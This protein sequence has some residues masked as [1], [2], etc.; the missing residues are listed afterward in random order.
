MTMARRAAREG[1]WVGVSSRNGGIRLPMTPHG[2]SRDTA[3]PGTGRSWVFRRTMIASRVL[4]ALLT[5]GGCS[6][7]GSGEAGRRA[8][9]TTTTTAPHNPAPGIANSVRPRRSCAAGSSARSPASARTR[10]RSPQVEYRAHRFDH[11][12]RRPARGCRLRRARRDDR[13]QRLQDGRSSRR[14]GEQR[15]RSSVRRRRTAKYALDGIH[16]AVADNWS[17]QPDT[18]G[19]AQQL[20]DN[21]ARHISDRLCPGVSRSTGSQRLA[22]AS[23]SCGTARQAIAASA[24][25]TFELLDR[26]Q[27]AHLQGYADRLAGRVRGA[28]RRAARRSGS[29]RSATSR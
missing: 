6:S 9:K 28:G 13:A 5:L 15:R 11:P 7:S 17:I 1:L 25:V 27:Y 22:A 8:T 24:A 29:P 16:W 2:R 21:S 14:M 26:S 18:Q 20:A 10:R 12:L 23:T 4:A 3:A 19:V